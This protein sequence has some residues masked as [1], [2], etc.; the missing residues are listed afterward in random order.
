MCFFFVC[1]YLFFLIEI[2]KVVTYGVITAFV[3]V[4][5]WPSPAFELF[6]SAETGLA[7]LCPRCPSG[8][9]GQLPALMGAVVLLVSA[10]VGQDIWSS[11]GNLN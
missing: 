7:G 10:H 5:S 6:G 2:L 9:L 4:L 3:E 11:E 1:F 8:E